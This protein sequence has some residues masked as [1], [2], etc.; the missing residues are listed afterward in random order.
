[1]S[2]PETDIRLKQLSYSSTLTLH[3]CPRRYQLYKLQSKGIDEGETT[4]FAF[5]HALGLGIQLCF[6]GKSE[7]EIIWALYRQWALD[8]FDEHE[9]RQESFWLAV[10]AIQ[11]FIGMRAAGFLSDYELVYYHGKPACE[12][13]FVIE[14]PDGFRYRGFVDAVLRHK[15]TGTIGVLEVKSTSL[16]DIDEAVYKNSAQAIGYSI[17][18][19][20]IFPDLSSY[21]VLYLPYKKKVKEYELRQYAKSY[22]QRALWIQELLL[23]IDTIKMYANAEIW[24]MRGES[25]YSFYRQC[26]YFGMCT[27]STNYLIKPLSKE[28]VDKLAAEEYSVKLTLMDLL[29][30][31]LAKGVK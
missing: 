27:L 6:E 1:M 21:D 26:E 24:P 15:S 30:S 19:D 17:V 16:N 3:S 13:G 22:L 28:V 11:K 9:K 20:A 2:A 8:L 7:Q 29:D 10:H 12:L 4:T 23:D 18:L 14:F 5:G 25:C 31:Q